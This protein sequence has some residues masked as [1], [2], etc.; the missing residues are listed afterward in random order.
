VRSAVGEV[1]H[2]NLQ[3]RV[4]SEGPA[5][6][7]ALA[8]A[9]NRMTA[10]L[11]SRVQEIEAQRAR[12]VRTEQLASVGRIAAGVA[13]E[14]GNPL[15]ALSGYVEL[16][17][18]PRTQPPLPEEQRE[19]LERSRQQLTRI[20]AIVGQLL[21][22]TRPSS[23]T[24]QDVE[25]RAAS[26]RLLTLVEHDARCE[27]VTLRV[28]GEAAIARADPA[29][30]DQVLQ[31]LVVNGCRAARRGSD[32]PQ[33]VVKVRSDDERVVVDVHDDGPGVSDEVRPRLFEPFFTTAK[34]GEG[35]GLGLAISQGLVEQM[36]GTLACLPAS[37]IEPLSPERSPGAVFRVT[38]PGASGATASNAPGP[39]AV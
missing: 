38:L 17:L 16:L 6:L 2:G 9:F 27:G 32:D 20:Q 25:L 7:Q 23:K 4:P 39:D 10:A 34:A 29:L 18:D 3:A 31:N 21:D 37:E 30:F 26:R 19:L 13:H 12:L 33:V 24:M 11:Q 1:E 22:F 15:A 8:E 28:E 36:E 14:V 5:E 35:T